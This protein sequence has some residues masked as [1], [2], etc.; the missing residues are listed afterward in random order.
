MNDE[1]PCGGSF[2]NMA[3]ST[4]Q[5]SVLTELLQSDGGTYAVSSVTD[6][7]AWCS[8]L[9]VSHYENFP[10]ASKLLPASMR[11]HVTAVYAYARLADD[12]ADEDWTH[13]Q[14]ERHA[15]LQTMQQL[16]EAAS[17]HPLEQGHPIAVALSQSIANKAIPTAPLHDLLLAFRQ[18]VDFKRPATWEDVMQYCR[19]SANPVGRIVLAIAGVRD[20]RAT[21]A[22]D[23]I[24]TAL[25]LVNFWQDLSIDI[26]RGRW[27]LPLELVDS[28]GQ[29][30][31]LLE[32][33]R[34]TQTLFDRGRIVALLVPSIRLRTELHAIIHGGE[35]MLGLCRDLGDELW[36]KRPILRKADYFSIAWRVAADLCIH[37][38]KSEL[39]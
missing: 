32:A 37:D 38:R 30:G 7:Y 5:R 39:A 26:P 23:D 4:S 11:P 29:H 35:R 25:Q 33:L 17:V 19:C 14:T 31:A 24:C 27:Y 34:R 1:P 10:V 22:S 36:T 20:I 8:R 13:D 18:D 15:A 28:F 3:T 21:E 16:V 2:C 9:A 6:A 12:I